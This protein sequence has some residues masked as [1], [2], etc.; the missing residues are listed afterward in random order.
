MRNMYSQYGEVLLVEDLL[1]LR[2][3]WNPAL[4][5]RAL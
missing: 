5:K 4:E 2:M 1:T 3:R